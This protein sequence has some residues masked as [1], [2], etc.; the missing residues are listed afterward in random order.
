[1]QELSEKDIERI[2]EAAAAETVNELEMRGAAMATLEL[3]IKEQAGRIADLEA[4]L[5]H[6][7]AHDGDHLSKA[8]RVMVDAVLDDRE[9]LRARVRELEALV[10]EL[11]CGDLNAFADGELSEQRHADF[12]RHMATCAKCAAGLLDLM[13]EIVATAGASATKNATATRRTRKR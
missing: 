2:A 8:S 6:A 5:A 4:D 1:M 10:N 13:Q 7:T 9:A 11:R 3:R 12:E